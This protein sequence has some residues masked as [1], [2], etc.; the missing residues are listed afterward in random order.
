VLT[1]LGDLFKGMGPVL[2]VTHGPLAVHGGPL[3]IAVWEVGVGL[4]AIVGHNNS[5]FLGFKGGKGIATTLGVVIALNWHAA[6]ACFLVWL[7]VVGVSRYSSLGSL[8]GAV[9]LPVSVYVFTPRDT[10]EEQKALA[11]YLGF[12]L[13]ATVLA[14]YKHRTNIQN[15]RN[16]T[17]RRLF[18]KRDS[19]LP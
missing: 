10:P 2:L 18:G 16:G 1:L 12:S 4:A 3:W 5:I 7:V 14:F 8:A 6:V 11:V 17:E 15:L 9:A 19:T 13:M